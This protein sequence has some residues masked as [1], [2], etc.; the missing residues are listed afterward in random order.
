MKNNLL[1]EILVAVVLVVL[2]VLF[3]N[4]FDFWMPT[5]ILMTMVFILVVA[6]ALFVSFVWRENG[7][8]ERDILHRMLAGR[9][10]YIVGTSVLV[11]GIILQ[12]FQHNLDPWLVLALGAM[13]LAKV[14][15]RVFARLKR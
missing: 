4:P 1:Q 5:T 8:D 15:G 13:I 14:G 12:C 9:M 6:F 10:A 7:G 11:L 3:L 2:L